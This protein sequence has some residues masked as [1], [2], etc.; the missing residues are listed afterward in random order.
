MT[1]LSRIDAL[2]RIFSLEQENYKL[3]D[4][5]KASKKNIESKN[6]QIIALKTEINGLKKQLEQKDRESSNY[7]NGQYVLSVCQHITFVYV[8]IL[9]NYSHVSRFIFYC[10]FC[11]F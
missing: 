7:S 9:F 6:Q 8:S 1:N 3:N 4:Q 5:L 11:P 2:E 10:I